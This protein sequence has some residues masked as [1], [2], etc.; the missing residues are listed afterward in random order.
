MTAKGDRLALMETFLRI[1]DAGSLSAA[2]VQLGTTQPT[3]SRRLGA[4]ESALGVR[5]LQRNTHGM[6]LTDPGRRYVT[7]AKS[8]LADWRSF[9]ADL[10]GDDDEP[11][12]ILR[13][14]APH[15]FGQDRL[16]PAVSTYLRRYPKVT[17]EW[18][19]HDAP[20]P[21]IEGG[22]DCVIRVGALRVEA[23]VAQKIFEVERILVAAPS[24][25]GSRAISRVSQLGALPWLAIG[26]FY[27]NSVRLE[28]D[29][30]TSHVVRFRPR[31][32]T[33]SLFAL[34]AAAL[35]GLGVAVVSAWLVEDDLARGRLVH[36]LPA[37]RSQPLPVYVAYPEASFYPAKLRRF[38]EVMRTA[39]A[40]DRI[41]PGRY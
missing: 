28:N 11:E 10:R 18:R 41:T 1:V 24:C 40:V 33:D 3:I 31:F 20:L 26:T 4:L 2:A 34:R 9:E 19:L 23:I 17:V 14:V 13:V 39:F 16:V 32:V 7:R 27:R 38:V 21:L 22:I 12:G 25:V 8:L 36:L 15:A 35:D 30:G 29:R 6:Q 5:L 37:W